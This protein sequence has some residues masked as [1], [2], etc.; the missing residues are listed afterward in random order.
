MATVSPIIILN[1]N[2]VRRKKSM[3]NSTKRTHS[4]TSTN[5]PIHEE[6]KSKFFVTPNRFQ[7]L[8]TEEQ[9]NVFVQTE[10]Q[11]VSQTTKTSPE[12]SKTKLP[13]IVLKNVTDFIILKKDLT[14][15]VGPGGFTCKANR[16]N[17]TVWSNTREN[18]M[19]IK[20]YLVE[21]NYE[22]HSYLPRSSQPF[23]V[24]LPLHHSYRGHN[25]L[26]K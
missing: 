7:V 8:S 18:W 3:E 10:S 13:N 1:K 24:V 21:A 22:Y 25:K 4:S 12:P 19:A 5:S 6:K 15:I 26:L 20:S 17:V 2:T 16:S 11:L 23:R 14:S 9:D